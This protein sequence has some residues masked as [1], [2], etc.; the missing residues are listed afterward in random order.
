M[1]ILEKLIYK[2]ISLLNK[3]DT[4][5]LKFTDEFDVNGI[6]ILS[7]DGW[8][9][10]THIYQTKPFEIYRLKLDNLSFLDCA[11]NHIVYCLKEENVYEGVWVEDLT[12]GDFIYTSEGPQR[13]IDIEKC[14]IDVNMCDVSVDSEDH[15][16]YAN[17]ILSH[18][19][20]TTALDLLHYIL[21][22]FDKTAVVLGNKRKTSVEILDKTKKIFEAIPFFLKPGVEK[23]NEGEVV[24]DN[25]CR[26][27]A[28]ATTPNS[29]IGYTV[30]FVIA[31]EFAHIKETIATEF[32]G[33]VF[34]VVTAARAIF[35]ITSTQN[36]YNL[37]YQ[38]YQN[39]VLG[40]N[41]YAPF[42]IDWFQV[43]E[44]DDETM[45]WVQR[46]DAWMKKQVANLGSQEAFNKQFGTQFDVSVNTLISKSKLREMHKV[47][48]QF[49]NYYKDDNDLGIALAN[50][51]YWDPDYD[52]EKNA[53]KDY[54]VITC[55]LAEQVGEDYTIY[56]IYKVDKGRLYCVGFFRDNVATRQQCAYS[57]MLLTSKV[58]SNERVIVSLEK[59]TYGDVFLKEILGIQ[60]NL[61]PEWD[62]SCLVK[63]YN[64]GGT[65]WT[66]GIKITAS[67]KTP[68]CILFKED[69]E[70]GVI[71]NHSTQFLMELDQFAND[72]TDHYASK[73]GHDDLIM[74]SVQL[75]FVKN[76]LQY[77]N[78]LE[79]AGTDMYDP[80]EKIYNPYEQL[81]YEY[82][83]N[84]NLLRLNGGEIT[85]A[86]RLQSY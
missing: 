68:H 46:D 49:E 32:Y 53:K 59:N 74:S 57:L 6:D 56:N 84:N 83:P 52:L 39:A 60:E 11:D 45:Q 35:R 30:H 7:N 14:G 42:K 36:G 86:Q 41:E 73:L 3:Y 61:L 24:F 40:V 50:S 8:H 66:W 29:A 48:I 10:I 62:Q 9:P 72:G 81:Q 55:D 34:P 65:K 80:E 20:T 47:E 2:V 13:V 31:D 64:E 12:P 16:Y 82:Q 58:F 76:T 85:N 43:P 70:R 75:M 77:K 37:F 5:D 1:K 71:N 17:N 28:E 15:T 26:I 44:W 18:N 67:N 54:F 51:Y 79:E 78:L 22:N 27:I 69:Y 63:Y 38:L 4:I 23:W 33:N 19:T 25:G 21:F